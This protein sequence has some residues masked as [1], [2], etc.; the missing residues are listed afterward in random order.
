M[1]KLTNQRET[2]RLHPGPMSSPL[3]GYK[4]ASFVT[5]HTIFTWS[6]VFTTFVL[7][8]TSFTTQFDE[9]WTASN[10]H[11]L[12]RARDAPRTRTL[13]I[14]L[15][16]RSNIIESKPSDSIDKRSNPGST[17]LLSRRQLEQAN[18]ARSA[19]PRTDRGGAGGV[20]GRRIDIVVSS[21][22]SSCIVLHRLQGLPSS[23]RT[24]ARRQGSQP[25][26]HCSTLYPFFAHP[27]QG[28]ERL[29]FINKRFSDADLKTNL[30]P[31]HR[32]L[33]RLYL[34]KWRRFSSLKQSLHTCNLHKPAT[35]EHCDIDCG[36]IS[37]MKEQ[38]LEA[39][40]GHPDVLLSEIGIK[41][42]ELMDGSTSNKEMNKDYVRL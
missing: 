19:P 32:I 38:T 33:S 36:S 12:F 17:F 24:R 13:I 29:V 2:Y 3:P 35:H 14:A 11:A 34:C 15:T 42:W 26:L 18:L 41:P 30:A 31:S 7:R 21:R 23:Q 4:N 40:L 28:L 8:S 20:D 27:P 39:L 10:M 5:L 22:H 25:S 6:G 37:P 16:R 1:I 9:L